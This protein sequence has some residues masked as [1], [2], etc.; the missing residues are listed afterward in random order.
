MI[1]KSAVSELSQVWE[2]DFQR[3]RNRSLAELEPL[4]FFLDAF[5]LSLRSGSSEKEG[6]LAAYAILRSG[7]KVLIHLA[8][9]GREN[10]DSWLAFLHDLTE[11]GFKEP[12][13]VISDGNPGLKKALRRIWPQ[14]KHQRCQRHKLLNI[15]VKLPKAM[16]AEM[17]RLVQQ[18]FWADSYEEGL[19]KGRALIVRFKDRYPAAMDCLEKDLEA[20][21]IYLKF[22]KEHRLRIRTTNG[23]ERI[24]EELKRRTKVVGRLPSEQAAL[25]LVFA[26]ASTYERKWRGITVTAAQL[27]QIDRVVAQTK[28]LPA[29][30]AVVT[31]G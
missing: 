21:L 8:L 9:G 14:V 6:I 20:C 26:V 16:Q 15:L 1:S 4:Y 17:K 23:L 12:A 30:R 31:G 27:A 5:Y 3:W 18:V 24:I 19:N 2:E 10:Y 25:K 22:P 28:Q 13:L 7:K 11:R 29:E